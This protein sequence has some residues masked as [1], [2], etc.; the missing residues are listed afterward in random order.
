MRLIARLRRFLG[1]AGPWEPQLAALA[2]QVAQL[3]TR[4]LP[5]EEAHADAIERE[6][7]WSEMNAQLR[8]YLGRLD[9]HAGYQRSK[10]EANGAE[11][12]LVPRSDVLAAKFPHGLPPGTKE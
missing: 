6:L 11:H 10:E 5:L 1:L 9:A 12:R 4:L 2:Q 8:R 7:K 3:E